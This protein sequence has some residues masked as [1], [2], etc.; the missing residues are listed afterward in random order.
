[1]QDR[2]AELLTITEAAREAGV[3]YATVH[4]WV[5]NGHLPTVLVA[6]RRRIRPADLATTRADIHA[7]RVV[8]V[9][10]QQ[11]QEV[12]ARLRLLREA[13]GWNQLQLAAASGL[14]HEH[15][16]RLELGHN[17]AGATT[18]RKLA[19]ALKVAP[20]QFIG[21]EPLGLT[22]L[23]VDEVANRLDVPPKRVRRWLREGDLPGEKVSG[24]WRVPMIVVAELERSGRLR[25]RSR[26]LDPRYRG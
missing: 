5:N 21:R 8:L 7:G 17:W 6:G 13:A 20:E 19:E 18:V 2:P 23:T 12:G 9:W 25:G 10:R 11:P 4:N 26:R 1:M 3:S 24:E 15:I 16:S 22:M 14:T